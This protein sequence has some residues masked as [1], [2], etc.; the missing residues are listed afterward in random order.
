MRRDGVRYGIRSNHTLK[1]C[2]TCLVNGHRDKD[3]KCEAI[4]TGRLYEP[5][6]VAIARFTKKPLF[7]CSHSQGCLMCSH[8]SRPHHKSHGKIKGSK[9]ERSFYSRAGDFSVCN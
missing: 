6:I 3:T 9:K 7:T 2:T 8:R 4:R 1:Y 5:G